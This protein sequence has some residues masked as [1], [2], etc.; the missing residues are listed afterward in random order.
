MA[1]LSKPKKLKDCKTVVD[2]AYRER[3]RYLTC[4][5]S[6]QRYFKRPLSDFWTGNLTGFDIVAFDKWIN[7]EQI[8]SLHDFIKKNYGDYAATLIYKLIGKD[9]DGNRSEE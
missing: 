2:F 1:K 7:P 6:F 9:E 4:H 8:L 5:E 3:H